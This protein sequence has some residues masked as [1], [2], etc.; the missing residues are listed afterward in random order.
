MDKRFGVIVKK[1]FLL[2]I[3]AVTLT[4]EKLE[5]LFKELTQKGEITEQ[6]AHMLLEEIGKKVEEGKKTLEKTVTLA[7]K[8][9][10]D[11]MNLVTKEELKKL[12]KRIRALEK[13]IT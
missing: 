7:V 8:R 1:A 11:K 4:K 3:G 12:E 13:K 2:G 9:A 10:I 6:Q 5:N